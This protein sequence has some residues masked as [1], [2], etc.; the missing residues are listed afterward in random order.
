MKRPPRGTV[1]EQRIQDGEQLAL[2]GDEGHL[3]GLAGCQ[4]PLIELTNGRIETGSHQSTHVQS[5]PHPRSSAPHRPTAAQSAGVAVQGSHADQGGQALSVE[6]AQL[7]QLGQ[8]R[9]RQYRTHPR[10]APEQGFV[11]TPCSAPLDRLVQI[12]FDALKFPLQ[13]PHVCLDALLHG[14]ARRG[15]EA[16]SFGGEH[17]H[18][19][20]PAG[21]YLAESANLLVWEGFRL[22]AYRLAK[23]GEY[24]GVESIGFSE[25][26][27]RTG[28]VV[29]Y[30]AR[31][32]HHDWQLR[33]REGGG[34]E[35]LEA[36]AGF[37]NY[38]GRT[39]LLEARDEGSDACLL[40]GNAEVLL[41]RAQE[42]V[43]APFGDIHP[44]VAARRCGSAQSASPS[45]G[46]VLADAGSL[47]SSEAAAP[48][49]VRAPFSRRRARRPRL[50]SGLRCG[51]K[52][53]SVCHT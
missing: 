1:L 26:S 12:A 15:A 5:R 11:L 18:D 16:V 41:H 42:D 35:S 49:T 31:I 45:V 19:L 21:Q 43:Q 39:R 34:H 24:L 48:A 52:E 2:A 13:P 37:Q 7:G 23:A 51:T 53:A 25:L 3:L 44:R 40:I 46:P 47:F 17:A 20:A 10:H 36:A 50:P 33:G 32:N 29:A 14:F 4:Q 38:E 9:P 8:Q 6:C 22:G 30:L 28:E 27:R